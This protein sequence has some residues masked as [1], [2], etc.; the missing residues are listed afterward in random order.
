MKT[1]NDYLNDPRILNDPEM[2]ASP[3]PVREV[4]AARLKI[5]DETAGMSDPERTDYYHQKSA[6]FFSKL[7]IT[8]QYVNFAGQGRVAK[9]VAAR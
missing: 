4:H 7:G 3:E 5:Q 2:M 8:P 9:A 6:S 1:L